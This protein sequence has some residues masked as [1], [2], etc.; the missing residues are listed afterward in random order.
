MQIHQA[1]RFQLRPNGWQARRMLS[2]AGSVPIRLQPFVG[3][4]AIATRS[5]RAGGRV[6]RMCPHTARRLAGHRSRPGTAV[7]GSIRVVPHIHGPGGARHFVGHRCWA[8]R[9]VS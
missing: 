4:A 3:E 5:R 6:R 1:Y 7:M 8:T 9:E 2:Y